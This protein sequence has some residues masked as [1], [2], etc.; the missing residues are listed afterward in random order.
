MNILDYLKDFNHSFTG[1]S[2]Y[3][4]TSVNTVINI[5]DR[6]VKP[7]RNKLPKVLCIDEVHIKSNIKYPYA[8]V[9]FDF[10]NSKIIDVLKTRRKEY[11]TRYFERFS[12]AELDNVE[13]VVMDL[14]AP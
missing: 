8:C 2:R 14:W 5:F 13:Y 9:L 3:F 11:L 7:I 12:I 4:N 10:H 1:A 6:Y